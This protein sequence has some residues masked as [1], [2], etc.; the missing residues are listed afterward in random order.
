MLNPVQDHN[1]QVPRLIP[2]FD[3]LRPDCSKCFRPALQVEL[4][5]E[6]AKAR[7]L[8][9]GQD[10]QE[11]HPLESLSLLHLAAPRR[12]LPLEHREAN[13]VTSVAP[14]AGVFQSHASIS[15][16]QSRP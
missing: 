10:R 7:L 9:Q 3:P 2:R 1:W 5:C 8:F 13:T 6:N 4:Y 15:T 11:I 12:S 16:P 14:R